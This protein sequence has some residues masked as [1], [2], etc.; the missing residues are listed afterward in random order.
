MRCMNAPRKIAVQLR[1]AIRKS[2]LELPEIARR[3]DVPYTSVYRFTNKEGSLRLETAESIA[4]ALG[5][6]LTLK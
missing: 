4:T 6:A 3:A 1:E 5:I 2:G